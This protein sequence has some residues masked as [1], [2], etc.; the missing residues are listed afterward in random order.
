MLEFHVLHCTDLEPVG[1]ML[2]QW[3]RLC[4]QAVD[5]NANQIVLRAVHQHQGVW[6]ICSSFLIETALAEYAQNAT[7]PTCRRGQVRCQRKLLRGGV[8]V[9]ESDPVGP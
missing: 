2:P 9:V 8:G 6:P 3:R 4:G 7:A 5:L 1:L